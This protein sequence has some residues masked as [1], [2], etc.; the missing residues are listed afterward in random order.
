M[1]RPEAKLEVSLSRGAGA[2]R[3]RPQPAAPGLPQDRQIFSQ[4]FMPS[5]SHHELDWFNDFRRRNA[6]PENAV[7]FLTAFSEID[8]RARLHTS[9]ARPSFSTPATISAFRS[10]S[11]ST[12]PPAFPARP[13]SRSTP[14]TTSRS[15]ASPPPPASPN[16][17]GVPARPVSRLALSGCRRPGRLS[18]RAASPRRDWPRRGCRPPPASFPPAVK[19]AET[20]SRPCP[21]P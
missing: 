16:A 7:R 14:T 5:A 17:R 11:A 20:E 10:R 6:G 9:N 1:P 19:R 21:V 2:D 13:W 8:V 15:R 4:T 18:L 12:L 3:G